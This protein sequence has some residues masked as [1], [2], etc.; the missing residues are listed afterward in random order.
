MRQLFHFLMRALLST[1]VGYR[2]TLRI[3]N[4]LTWHMARI[5]CD[6]C[7]R[8]APDGGV[9][10]GP[11]RGMVYPRLEACGSV[12]VPKLLGSYEEELHDTLETCFRTG[13]SDVVDIGCAEGYYA[14]GCAMRLP[15]ARVHAFD[16]DG[17]ARELCA[18]LAAANGVA[19][20]VSISGICTPQALR[21]L[22]THG[23]TLIVCDCEGA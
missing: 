20:R 11:F 4:S 5:E 8:I 10:G 13:Y 16:L 21:T 7:R 3:V 18:E 15:K 6:L 17:R 2:A 14:V 23:R 12:L 1:S 22:E 9:H 19:Q